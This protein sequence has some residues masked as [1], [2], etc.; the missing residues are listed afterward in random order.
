M[1]K[2]IIISILLLLVVSI[3][4]IEVAIGFKGESNPKKEEEKDNFNSEYVLKI[5]NLEIKL[6]SEFSREKYGTEL[7]YSEIP[8]C[9]FEGL[10][11]TYTY[12]YYEINTFE[13]NGKEKILSVYFLDPNITTTENVSLG[14]DLEKMT[15]TYGT[16]Y[17]KNDNLYT[18]KKGKT[19]IEFIVEND[20]ITSIEYK[21][22]TD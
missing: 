20:T 8:S 3:G 2:K 4:A 22:V 5:N 10:D 9:A 16:N 17:E 13:D 19:S 21:Y 11:K 18:Y 6:G 15:S 14:D 1:N 7:E 12:E